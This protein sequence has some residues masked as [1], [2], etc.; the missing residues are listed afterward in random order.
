[1]EPTK[2]EQALAL[3]TIQTCANIATAQQLANVITDKNISRYCELPDS[4]R[5]PWMLGQIQLLVY[6]TQKKTESEADLALTTTLVDRAIITDIRL[7]WLT[8]VEITDAILKGASKEFGEFY[9][10][11]FATVM[12]FLRA[13]LEDWKRMN[14]KAIILK[15]RLE[16][17]RNDRERLQSI[18]NEIACM[19]ASGDFVPT[20]G[21]DYSFKKAQKAPLNYQKMIEEQRDEIYRLAEK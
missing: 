11:T 14:A 19:K 15:Q 21:P 17:D 9:G 13:Y 2:T 16:E 12:S 5:L 6:I 8:Q 7:K 3:Q 20:W 10:A 1:M 4:V 18:Q